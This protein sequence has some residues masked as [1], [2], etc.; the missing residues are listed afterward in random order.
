MT[1]E[2]NFVIFVKVHFQ[3]WLGLE[4]ILSILALFMPNFDLAVH[5]LILSISYGQRLF[6]SYVSWNIRGKIRKQNEF[7]IFSLPFTQT[8][9]SVARKITLAPFAQHFSILRNSFIPSILLYKNYKF[10]ENEWKK[11]INKSFLKSFLK[12]W[13]PWKVRLNS[14]AY[15]SVCKGWQVTRLSITTSFE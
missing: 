10:N 15:L 2:F 11:H 13:W 8:I 9:Y 4:Y 3:I 1:S 12:L 7:R 6:C 14:S 5:L